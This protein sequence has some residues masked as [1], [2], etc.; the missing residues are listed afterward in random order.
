MCGFCKGF[1][2][3]CFQLQTVHKVLVG[4]EG[5]KMRKRCVAALLKVFM[6]VTGRVLYCMGAVK[7]TG[8]TQR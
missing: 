2:Q 6:Q 7:F 5:F 3:Q 1:S 4:V 8:K